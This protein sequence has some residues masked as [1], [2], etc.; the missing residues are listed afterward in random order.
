MGLPPLTDGG[1]HFLEG[2]MAQHILISED[3][4]KGESGGNA[5]ALRKI[6]KQF[7]NDLREARKDPYDNDFDSKYSELDNDQLDTGE[8]S[9][10]FRLV[11]VPEDLV[12]GGKAMFEAR[13]R[14]SVVSKMY[15]IA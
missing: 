6:I 11:D 12:V 2:M 4:L 13:F 8:T 5:K 7:R 10:V 9:G 3:I 14:M 15:L 1:P